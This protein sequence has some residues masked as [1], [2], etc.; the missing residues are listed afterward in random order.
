MRVEARVAAFTFCVVLVSAEAHSGSPALTFTDI[1][2]SAGV[3]LPGVLTESLAWGDYDNDGDADLYLTNQTAN[4]L[5]RN[6][7]GGVF[8]D[9]T[10]ATG[11]GDVNWGVGTAFGDLDNDGDLDLY[12]VN[13]NSGPD[14]LY[15]NDGPIGAGGEYVFT[16][17]AASAGITIE[18][19]SR[20]M[21]LLDY[22]RDGLLDIYVMAIGD[23]I[24]YH[25]DGG[26]SFTDVS[27]TLGLQAD[28]QGVGV[29]CTDIDNNGWVDIFTG[30]RTF[31]LSSLFM[32][33]N[34]T[35]TNIAAAAGIDGFGL[36]MGVLSMDYDNDQDMDLYWTTWPNGVVTP[37]PNKF[38]ENL[39]GM[40]FADVTVASGTQDPLGWGISCNAGDIDNDGFEDMCIT[41][42]FD[43][44]SGP[45]VLFRNKGD[46]TFEDVTAA[47]G[48][49]AFDGRG[50]AFADFDNDGDLDLCITGDAPDVTKLWRNDTNNGNHWL[51][52]RL[53]GT[54]S[55]RSAIGAR[56][57]VTAGA[58]TLVKEVS[59]GAGRGSAND[60][61]VEFGL[62]AWDQFVDVRIRW[63]NGNIL[64]RRLATVDAIVTVVETCRSDFNGD[65]SVG[66]P[67]LAL[68]LGGWGGTPPP[69]TDL[70][71]D[72]ATGS[73]DLALL[74]G[75]WGAC[76]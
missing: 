19:S 57:E 58:L 40:S 32:N 35:F 51:T 67:D 39:D 66:A 59:G 5:F 69:F 31:E 55:N 45:N 17:I 48:G 72:G 76:P 3:E 18:R 21:A 70:D 25:N 13:F 26:L 12:V 23:N 46:K 52:I 4:R 41:N 44:S 60:L 43:A 27:P 10:A 74:L 75:S 9:V 71:D 56:I 16:N 1:S 54:T 49:G 30:N 15:R 47:I 33:N 24:L 53:E 38:Y 37:T 2:A 11:T 61:P 8:T 73:A 22:D 28:N 14:V 6:D 20:G 42:G 65:G 7:G 34:A 64:E 36:G 68:L 63:P 50:V 29:V 62:G